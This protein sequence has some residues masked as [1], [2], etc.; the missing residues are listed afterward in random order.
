MA[1]GAALTF[2]ELLRRYRM[3]KGLT[4]EQLAERA[5]L[6]LRGISDLERGARRAPRRDTVLLL[7]QA[8]GLSDEKRAALER[9]VR[10]HAARA[11]AL[12]GLR[13]RRSTLP[14]PPGP[15]IGRER[16]VSAVRQQVLEPA[17]R[18]RTLTGPGGVG[19]T[20]LALQVADQVQDGFLDGV[21]FVGLAWLTDPGLVPSTLAQALG[22][23]EAGRWPLV[24]HLTDHLRPHRCCCSSTTLST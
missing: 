4:Q 23:P 21:C 8:L 10:T 24:E 3:A 11:D 13:S 9:A 14:A 17:V 20:R 22:I 6:S 7:A 18:L 12:A 15:F 2:A 19:K 16:E 1:E 5:G